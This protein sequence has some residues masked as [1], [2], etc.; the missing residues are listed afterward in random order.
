MEEGEVQTLVLDV[1]SGMAKCGF[2]GDDTP[3]AVFPSIVGVPCHG[4]EYVGEEA[5]SKRDT[6]T[7]TYPLEFGRVVNWARMEQV[8]FLIPA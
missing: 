8:S 1:G 3:R 2:A 5:L 7:L 4:M 6:L